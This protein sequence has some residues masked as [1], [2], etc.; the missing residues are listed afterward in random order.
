MKMG[1]GNPMSHLNAIR[2]QEAAE[3]ILKETNGRHKTS[4]D[5]EAN[6]PPAIALRS[7]GFLGYPRHCL[8][9]QVAGNR[10]VAYSPSNNTVVM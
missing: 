6:P 1:N 2:Q 9:S 5:D 3:R 7:R 10:A 8:A 4:H